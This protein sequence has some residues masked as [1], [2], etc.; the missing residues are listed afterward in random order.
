M[1]QTVIDHPE[2][3]EPGE[4]G[5]LRRVSLA[6]TWEKEDLAYGQPVIVTVRWIMIVSALILAIWNVDSM[7][8]LRLQII[9][10]LLLAV[11]NFYLQAQL[12]MKRPLSSSIVY[13]ASAVDIAMISILVL[14]QGGYSSSIYV[15][16][17][18]AIAA[19]AVAFPRGLTLLYTTIV[20][21]LYGLIC[22]GTGYDHTDVIVSRLL[23]IVAVAYCGSLYLQLEH[24]R[25]TE[26]QERE[27]AFIDNISA[28]RVEPA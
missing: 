8:D 23:M 13:A 12:L 27:E 20:I 15:F 2:G 3:K 19:F 10:I 25:R 28:A 16:Y 9:A 24:R 1:S 18:P 22:L 5:L 6:D 14:F 4:G 17:L 11:T 7:A 21:L 26:A